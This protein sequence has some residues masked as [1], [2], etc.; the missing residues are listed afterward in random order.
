MLGVVAG[1]AWACLAGVFAAACAGR[2]AATV[3]TVK[4]AAQTAASWVLFMVVL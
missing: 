1:V 4:T 2:E 3:R